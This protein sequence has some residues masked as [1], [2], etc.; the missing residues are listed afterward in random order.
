[1]TCP[2]RWR[3]VAARRARVRA[4]NRPKTADPLPDIAAYSARPAQRVTDARFRMP[5][6]DRRLEI[7]P[8]FGDRESK[9]PLITNAPLRPAAAPARLSLVGIPP[10]KCLARADANR[11]QR[12]DNPGGRQIGERKQHVAPIDAERSAALQKVRDV[13]AK[14]TSDTQYNLVAQPRAPQ[15]NERAQRGRRIAAA[16]AQSGLHRNPFG[17][18]HAHTE[19]C[20]RRLAARQTASA[21]RHT[22]F[23]SLV[24]QC[25]SVQRISN[26]P[27]RLV[28]VSVSWSAID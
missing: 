1:M 27:A 25:G 6:H 17:D 16:T 26:G 23:E 8:Q 12:Q 28:N 21:A 20:P 3:R 14:I 4:W 11:G 24:G 5:R 10:P 9:R 18:V 15:V 22:R 13:G 19:G 2:L 7:V